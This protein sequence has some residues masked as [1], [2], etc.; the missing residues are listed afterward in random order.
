M[1]AKKSE[2]ADIPSVSELEQQLERERYRLNYLRT[3]QHT[4][5]TLITVAAL[6]VLMAV[7]L[8]PVLR[9]YGTSMTPTLN[10]GDIVI[11][12]ANSELER[13]DI[14]AFYYNNKV[15][16]KRVIAV[17]GEWVDIDE[18]GT[19]YVN[20]APLDEPYLTE[21]ALGDCNIELPYQVPE[22]KF[23]VMGDHRSVSQ[24]SRNA[25]IGCVSEEMLVGVL[26]ICVWPLSEFGVIH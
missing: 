25:S 13:G 3:M 16:V 15:L 11:A 22:G 8:F 1:H 26:K 9:I 6:A 2:L 18:N 14:I 7:F 24:D 12:A 4:I 19:V 10:G 20:D 23:F 21:T 17:A 5:F